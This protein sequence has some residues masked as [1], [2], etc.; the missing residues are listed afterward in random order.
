MFKPD[1][2]I[3]S[4][5]QDSLQRWPFAKSLAES[6]LKYE[7]QESIAI[8]LYGSWGAGKTSVINLLKKAIAEKSLQLNAGH[9]PVIVEFRPWHYSDQNQLIAM[10]FKDLATAIKHEPSIEKAETNK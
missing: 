1:R 7:R 10:F 8:A 3:Q 9:R 2:P 6:I 5:D 4:R